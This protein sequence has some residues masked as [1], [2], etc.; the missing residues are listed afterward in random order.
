[1][2]ASGVVAGGKEAVLVSAHTA[3][4]DSTCKQNK[5]CSGGA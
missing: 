3:Q 1:M 2:Q 5:N 4:C